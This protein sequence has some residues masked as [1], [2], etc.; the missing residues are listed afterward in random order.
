[1]PSNTARF[2]V[3]DSVTVLVGSKAGEVA[4]VEYVIWSERDRCHYFYLKQPARRLSRGYRAD[5]LTEG[6]PDVDTLG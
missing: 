3:G 1:M 5:E 6:K 2:A 4:E